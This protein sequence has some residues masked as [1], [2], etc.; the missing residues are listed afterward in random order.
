MGEGEV[1]S[2]E[3]GRVAVD[4]D[5]ALGGAHDIHRPDPID[6]LE[7]IADAVFEE[8]GEPRGTFLGFDREDGYRVSW[9]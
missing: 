9:R 3:L 5:D 6:A 2:L 1:I 7:A 8:L 4:L